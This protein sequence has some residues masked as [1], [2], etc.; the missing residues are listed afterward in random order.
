MSLLFVDQLK[1]NCPDNHFSCTNKKCVTGDS[2]CD[3]HDDCGDNSDETHGCEGR[4]DYPMYHKGENMETY[5]NSSE[6]F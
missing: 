5:V 2:L 3:G 4:C 1:T 6:N